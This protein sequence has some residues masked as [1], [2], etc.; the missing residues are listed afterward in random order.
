M[1]A[2][3]KETSD[4]QAA[5][6]K[7]G[8]RCSWIRTS[9]GITALAGVV[10]AGLGL[11]SP[12]AS[13][14]AVPQATSTV[15]PAASRHHDD[16]RV[17][18]FTVTERG[19]RF[20]FAAP[21]SWERFHSLPS[22]TLR[23]G[24]IS[25]NKSVVGPQGAEA[26][27]Y[28]TSFPNGKYAHTCSDVLGPNVGHSAAALAAAVARAPGTRLVMGPSSVTVGGHAA[29]H[30]VLEVRKKAGCDPGFFY[31]W[32]AVFGGALWTTTSVDDKIRVWVV[33]V[34]GTR[35]FIAAM[36][37]RLGGDPRSAAAASSGESSPHNS[38]I[39]R[40]AGT[41]SLG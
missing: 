2:I 9:A 28:W 1:N 36:T 10:A 16:P 20:S 3:Q 40:S 21:R 31:S 18:R 15:T 19:V 41:T 13:R 37:S 4:S 26:I 38:S 7:R 35:L 39:R 25:L 5:G 17:A 23:R 6:G 8:P 27:I 22:A 30:V 29:K 33:P 24:P 12:P 14:S 34:R 11:L 32:R